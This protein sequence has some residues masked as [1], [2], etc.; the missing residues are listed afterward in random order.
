MSNNVSSKL[1]DQNLIELAKQN[2][3]KQ[4]RLSKTPGVLVQLPSKGLI[5]PESSILRQGHVEMRHM[6]AY[7][8]D[9]LTTSSYIKEGI[10]LDKLLE[11]L[12]LTPVKLDDISYTDR[13]AMLISAR[14][15]GYGKMYPVVVTHPDTNVQY[16]REIDLSQ[17]KFKPFDLQP[18][19]NGEFEYRFPDGVIVKYRFLTSALSKNI[20]PEKMI[21]QLMESSIMEIN[22]NRDKNFI[23][24]YIKYE[25]RAIDARNFRTFLNDN[26]SGLDFNMEF[27]GEDGSTFTAMFQYGPDLFW[28]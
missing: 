20:S 3:E 17:I 15:Y 10:V 18:D 9:I 12:L 5:Y 16:N 22:G 13:E 2:Y 7:D 26:I 21:S 23:A 24:D 11:S 6:T 27:E 28:F 8:E 1:Q 19:A 25:M 4:Q 14:I